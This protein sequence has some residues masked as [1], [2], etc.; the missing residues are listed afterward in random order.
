MSGIEPLTGTNFSTWIDQVKLTLGVMDLDHALHI[1][2]PAALTAESTA[3]Q[4]R[5][6][7]QWGRSNHMSLMIIKN[8]IS[9]AIRG[10][11]PDSEN[12]KEYLSS[13]EEQFK[14]TSK[15][16]ASTLIIKM[17]TT[18]Y[19][20]IDSGSMVHIANSLQGFRIIRRLKRNQQTFKVGNGVD[21]D[22]EA[23]G[24]LSLIMEGGFCL[25]LYGT[26]YGKMTKGNKKGATRSTRLLELIYMDI[27]GPFPLGIGG[28]KS[29]ITFIDDYSRYMYLF[30][31]NEKSESLEMFKTFKAEVKNQIDRKIKV[32]RS[33]REGKYYGRH[34]D[35]GQALGSFFDF[36]KDHE[37]INQYTMAGTPQP[38]GVVERRNRTLMDMVRSMLT[39]S[40]LP[41]FLWT[42]ALKTVVHI[43]NIVPSKSVPETPYEIW[44]RRK[45]SLRYLRVDQCIYLK[46]SGTN[47]IILVLYVDDILLASN[48]I[49]LLHESKRSLSRNFDMK[50]LGKASYVIG[51]EI[52]QDRANRKLGLSQKEYIERVLNRF[53]MQ[54]CSHTVAPVIKGDVFGSHQCPKT[55]V[56]YEEMKRIP[57]AFVVGSL[58]YAQVC[59]RSDIT[60]I[61]GMLGGFQSNPGLLHW[62]DAKKV[63]RYLQGTKEYK[64]TYTRSDNLEVI[65]YSDSDFAK[66]KDTNRSTS[67][68]ILTLSENRFMEKEKQSVLVVSKQKKPLATLRSSFKEFETRFKDWLVNDAFSAGCVAF[69]AGAVPYAFGPDNELPYR[70]ATIAA[71]HVSSNRLVPILPVLIGGS[72][73]DWARNMAVF[74]GV[75]GIIDCSMRRLR[76]KDDVQ[77]S[78]V[79]GFGA[80]VMV[81]MVCGINGINVIANGVLFALFDV[82]CF[83][84][85]GKSSYPVE[86]V[87]KKPR[88]MLPSLGLDEYE[89]NLKNELLSHKT[90]PLLDESDLQEAK[91]PVGARRLIFD[92]VKRE[93][94]TEGDLIHL[95]HINISTS[96]TQT[97]N[98]PAP[99]PGLIWCVDKLKRRPWLQLF[100]KCQ[101]PASFLLRLTSARSYDF[102][103]I[104]TVNHWVCNHAERIAQAYP[105]TLIPVAL[106]SC[107]D[108]FEAPMAIMGD[109]DIPTV[110]T[111]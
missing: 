16:H 46:M 61:C 100:R 82:A 5:A 57:Y 1:D 94:L 48:N 78:M 23:I 21:L 58:T 74:G 79:R 49:D 76:G 72:R 64:L 29:F 41:E 96:P 13:V 81:S 60:Y 91:I 36:C 6:Y 111:F 98:S 10:A 17:L 52:H 53:N 88:D 106:I 105:S 62:K 69:L 55:E 24:T 33:D 65:G 3:D 34:T 35:V 103:R 9:V 19:D 93:E 28:H 73:L 71:K 89:K 31:I 45:L 20:G 12:A 32:V 66:C 75:H 101:E 85:Y 77:I 25:N 67:E 102:P 4:K 109:D 42:E 8:S 86:H 50:D 39:N 2:P 107:C 80:R 59:T 43:L 56:E 30:L 7:E 47:F 68:Y 15:A 70:V 84:L 99:P 87:Y 18:K 83:K 104:G 44:T 108:K 92:H 54:H 37:I 14:R 26:I 51:I 95:I 27:C 11:I 22:V 38:D 90:F 97:L 110:V 63:L 40:N